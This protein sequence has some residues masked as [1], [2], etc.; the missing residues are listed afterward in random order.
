MRTAKYDGHL[1]VRIP[2]S[3]KTEF[4]AISG[5][6]GMANTIREVIANFV[7]GNRQK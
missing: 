7:N 3:L 4:K 2:R 5:E 1:T 6:R